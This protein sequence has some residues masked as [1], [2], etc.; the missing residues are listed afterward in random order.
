MTAEH[1]TP[2]FEELKQNLDSKI[3]D[4]NLRISKLDQYKV[5]KIQT[6]DDRNDTLLLI[7]TVSLSEDGQDYIY[8]VKLKT[9]N[10]YAE[11]E[12]DRV[13]E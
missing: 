4:D 2:I 8:S 12:E 11:K 13:H 1:V 6:D 5:Y 9:S 3:H 7:F 10:A